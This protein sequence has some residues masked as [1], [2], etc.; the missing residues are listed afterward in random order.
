MKLA[1]GLL[2]L[3]GWI[4]CSRA[5]L[6]HRLRRTA[7]TRHSNVALQYSASDAIIQSFSFTEC[8]LKKVDIAEARAEFW[9]FF[10]AGSGALGIGIAQIPKILKIYDEISQLGG[11]DLTLGGEDAPTNP[12]ATIGYPEKMKA[13]D[14]NQIIKDA[15]S[16]EVIA[17]LCE[18][19]SYL[20]S[21]GYLEQ[22]AFYK[23]LPD[24]NPL[25]KYAIFEAMTAGGC[26]PYF[27]IIPFNYNLLTYQKVVL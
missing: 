6:P 18:K 1:T 19:K 17:S 4:S 8:I 25:A 11:S 21:L 10:F 16:S 7:G 14:I 12:I 9:F 15:P 3:A 26:Y 2:L 24:S 27:I 22:Q 5:F 20:A 13:N 23:A